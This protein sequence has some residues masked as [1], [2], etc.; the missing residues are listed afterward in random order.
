MNIVGSCIK[1]LHIFVRWVF[2]HNFFGKPS[3]TL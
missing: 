3:V 1:E 2:S